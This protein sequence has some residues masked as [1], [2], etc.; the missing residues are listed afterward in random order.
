MSLLLS[1]LLALFSVA[2][3]G[4]E[5][6]PTRAN[7]VHVLDTI[8]LQ[9][10]T[11][12]V[13]DTVRFVDTIHLSDTM[14]ITSPNEVF[15]TVITV[16]TVFY[17]GDTLIVVD[18]AIFYDSLGTIDTIYF[19]DTTVIAKD[20]IFVGGS[21]VRALNLTDIDIGDWSFLENM[22]E[23]R[24]L[25]ISKTN[26]SNSDKKYLKSL[27]YLADLDLRE[28][29]I[30]NV[31]ELDE[32]ENLKFLA[33]DGIFRSENGSNSD[34]LDEELTV[35]G[36]D[37]LEV[38][39]VDGENGI[40]IVNIENLP[41][42]DSLFVTGYSL[43]TIN[44]S[45]LPSLRAAYLFNTDKRL[46]NITFSDNIPLEYLRTY[47]DSLVSIADFA[48]LKSLKTLSLSITSK[49]CSFDP[50]LG[51]T[52]LSELSIGIETDEQFSSLMN[53]TQL[54]SVELWFNNSYSIS[55][56]L[57]KEIENLVNLS[58][59]SAIYM[60]GVED[61]SPLANL[62][63]L[64]S[65]Y[66]Y[67]CTSIKTIAE[68]SNLSYFM[69][70]WMPYITGDDLNEIMKSPNLSEVE[71]DYCSN[72]TDISSLANATSLEKLNLQSLRSLRDIS[73]LK[74]L[75][76]IKELRFTN[77]YSQISDFT[78]LLNFLGSGD[79]YFG[80]NTY[81]PTEIISQLEAAGVTTYK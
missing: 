22:R 28:T 13:A 20:T 26:F 64:D 34:I 11:I 52:S 16:D 76:S 80:Y 47:S 66:L 32:I 9:G 65:L 25:N 38:L 1:T 69:I 18:T 79:S 10:D 27:P 41:M 30:T 15:D 8:I 21:G 53:I 14:S 74:D 71:L 54:K 48:K 73:A 67:N 36:F 60:N 45:N 2:L 49:E 31:D 39:S 51:A 50:L 3:L 35:S 68:H 42:L 75:G 59:L 7:S 46:K 56:L 62:P 72:I 40:K 4:C 12:L 55:D 6:A 19:L 37:N 17:P 78:P 58:S 70:R 77:L 81:T 63:K 29:G 33:I 24:Y 5:E 57:F 23:L 61:I 44:L 43:D